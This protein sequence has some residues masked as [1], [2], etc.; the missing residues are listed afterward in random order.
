[1]CMDLFKDDMFHFRIESESYVFVHF[2]KNGLTKAHVQNCSDML[3]KVFEFYTKRKQP[4]FVVFNLEKL[5]FVNPTLVPVW[6]SSLKHLFDL[7]EEHAKGY[8]LVIQSPTISSLVN[9]IVK[10]LPKKYAFHVV[11]EFFWNDTFLKLEPYEVSFK[12]HEHVALHKN[13]QFY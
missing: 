2:L 10:A 9:I 4:F 11:D 12:K 5:H 1:M 3:T 8:V 7:G 6:L 13:E